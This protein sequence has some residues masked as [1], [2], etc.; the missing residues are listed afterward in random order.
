MRLVCARA[1]PH[2]PR[3]CVNAPRGG[4]FMHAH[5]PTEDRNEMNARKT[6]RPIHRETA[7]LI[8]RHFTAGFEP[9]PVS[10]KLGV[11]Y[12]AVRDLKKLWDAWRA[13]GRNP[14]TAPWLA[15]QPTPDVN[16]QDAADL[17]RLEEAGRGLLRVFE[18][19]EETATASERPSDLRQWLERHEIMKSA[20]DRA[21]ARRARS[22]NHN[23]Y[24]DVPIK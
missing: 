17:R 18:S 2:T 13:D 21:A 10:E 9:K 19:E 12:A 20:R 24:L 8:C 22:P 6:Y 16:D 5:A 7:Q 1:P 15:F 23:P 11:T 4:V 3:V 14:D